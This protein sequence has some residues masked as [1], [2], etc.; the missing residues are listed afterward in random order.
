MAAIGGGS[1]LAG[2][3]IVAGVGSI[4]AKGF[5]GASQ[6]D[7]NVQQGAAHEMYQEK[8]GLLGEQKGLA[9]KAAESQFSGGRRDVSMGTQTG[10]RG[11]QEGYATAA[12]QSG[13]ATSGT[14]QQQTKTQTE[15][16]KKLHGSYGNMT[17]LSD[18]WKTCLVK[19]TRWHYHQI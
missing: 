18:L 8:L 6:H 11:I 3:G 19:E 1:A 10:M 5:G 14:I 2:A 9:L 17:I 15:A 13:L 16:H 4:A 7:I 12:S